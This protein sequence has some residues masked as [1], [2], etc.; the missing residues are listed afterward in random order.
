MVLASRI[1]N[2]LILAM[3]TTVY[4]F[5]FIK[6]KLRIEFSGVG[7]LIMYFLAQILRVVSTFEKYA[8][9]SQTI[10][11]LPCQLLI[12]ISLYY[13]TFEILDIKLQLTEVDPIKMKSSKRRNIIIKYIFIGYLWLYLILKLADIVFLES[14]I[15]PKLEDYAHIAIKSIKL[16]LDI[17]V[18]IIFLKL[19][20]FI[21]R[22]KLDNLEN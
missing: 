18:H 12:W 14:L 21:V 3:M 5:L 4:T 17:I 8:S 2:P 10:L 19:F 15:N 13:F 6:L 7:T 11:L 9:T 1:V 16:I 20:I 22:L